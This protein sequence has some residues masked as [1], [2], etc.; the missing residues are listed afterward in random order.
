M[1]V[2]YIV[3]A[4]LGVVTLLVFMDNIKPTVEDIGL[5]NLIKYSFSYYSSNLNLVLRYYKGFVAQIR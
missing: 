3:L 2:I 1:V 4:I 5:K